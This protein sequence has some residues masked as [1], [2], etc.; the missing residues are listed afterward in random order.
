[1]PEQGL[2]IGMRGRGRIRAV[3][4]ELS[5]R[6]LEELEGLARRRRTAQG[7]ARRLDAPLDHAAL[8]VD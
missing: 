7:T 4:I 1:M 2:K 3:S 6:E 5:D 8:A